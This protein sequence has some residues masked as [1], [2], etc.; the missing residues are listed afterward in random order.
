[1]TNRLLLECFGEKFDDVNHTIQYVTESLSEN[2]RSF[3]C[4][5][6]FTH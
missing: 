6:R 2:I 5:F 1:M 4:C 3:C